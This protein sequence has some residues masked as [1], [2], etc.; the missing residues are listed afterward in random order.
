MMLVV[1][2][3]IVI[4]AAVLYGVS[5][6]VLT[7]SYTSIEDAEMNKDLQRAND[8]LENILVQLGR[9]VSDW[10]I[11]DDTYNFVVTKDPKFIEDDLQAS[12]LVHLN[13][14]AMVYT[15]AN[16]DIAFIRT[17]DLKSQ[18]DTST[19][20]LARYIEEHKDLVTQK[21]MK[22]EMHGILPT[23]DGPLIFVSQPLLTSLG[24]GPIHGS[25]IFAKYLNDDLSDQIAKLTHLTIKM[26]PYDEASSPADVIRAKKEFSDS[27]DTFI[28]A[29][30]ADSVSGYK[31]L[32]DF[33]G[34]PILIMEV[35]KSRDV[36]QQGHFVFTFFSF[37]ATALISALG[38]VLVL[39][40]EYFVVSRF[41]K[42]AGQ[43]KDI[44][45]K[46]DLSLR[47]E[48]QAADEVGVLAAAIN[49]M[50]DKIALS[51]NIERKSNEEALSAAREIQ[52]RN[53]ELEKMNKLMIDREYKLIELK[54][55]NEKL[56]GMKAAS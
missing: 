50:L 38:L 34:K 15:D 56:K 31:L 47:I 41:T 8:A 28:V 49:G 40:L 52:M 46:H 39:L 36:Y 21:S 26:F 51:E 27:K 6:A 24:T 4:F 14:N 35:E 12:N 53:E 32:R 11:W 19:A 44:G 7:P 20:N 54:A 10:A 55:E 37:V 30:S 23:P 22:G 1:A 45:E 17:V 33:Y 42:L 43:V 3:T 13:I 2:V 16:N 5:S 18:A 25:L 29:D 48:G 9:S